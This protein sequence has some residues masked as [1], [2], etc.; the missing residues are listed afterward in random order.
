MVAVPDL[1]FRVKHHCFLLVQLVNVCHNH[2]ADQLQL[3]REILTSLNVILL[4]LRPRPLA[5]VCF[6][7]LM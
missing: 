4:I 7:L 5:Q 2:P 1:G 6:K 3:N